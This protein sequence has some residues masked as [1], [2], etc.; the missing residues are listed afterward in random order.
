VWYE[1][2]AAKSGQD[3]RILPK[4]G[5]E[6]FCVELNRD[7]TLKTVLL[8]FLMR[9]VRRYGKQAFSVGKVIRDAFALKY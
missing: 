8:G 9:N 2:L 1:P 5:A 7:I 4:G 6:Q 3:L